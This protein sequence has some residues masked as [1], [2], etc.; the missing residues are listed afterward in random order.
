MMLS[1][2]NSQQYVAVSQGF[3]AVTFTFALCIANVGVVRASS[4]QWQ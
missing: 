4:V 3:Y 2:F 1:L